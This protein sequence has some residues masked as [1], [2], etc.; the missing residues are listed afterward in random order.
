MGQPLHVACLCAAWCRTCDDY[1]A[2]FEAQVRDF[3]ALG[4]WV[5][6][7]DQ[8]AAL[9]GIEVENFPTLL[10]ARGDEVLFFG[11]IEPQPQTLRRLLQAARDGSLKPAALPTAVADLPA[12]LR[13]GAGTR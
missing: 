10:I 1:V 9:D 2:V 6:I 5:D 8:E 11:A 12:R 13:R 3:H 4:Q 7:E